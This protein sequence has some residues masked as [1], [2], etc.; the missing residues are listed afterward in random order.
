MPIMCLKGPHMLVQG[1]P[2]ASSSTPP[3]PGSQAPSPG[4]ILH[5]PPPAAPPQTPPPNLEQ[6]ATPDVT[7]EVRMFAAGLLARDPHTAHG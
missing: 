4:A 3:G 6:E 7:G 5:T 2:G 1:N